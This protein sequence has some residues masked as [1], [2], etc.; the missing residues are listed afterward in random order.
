MSLRIL[1]VLQGMYIF[2]DLQDLFKFPLVS[3]APIKVALAA[4]MDDEFTDRIAAV[5]PDQT[6]R[7]VD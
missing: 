1:Q 6:F 4:G 5:D 2:Q 7:F 3:P